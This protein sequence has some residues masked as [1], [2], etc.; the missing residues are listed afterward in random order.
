[1]EIP[2]PRRAPEMTCS[3]TAISEITGD[4]SRAE[5]RQLVIGGDSL[6]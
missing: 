1:M 6:F 5:A 4:A 3:G 2:K